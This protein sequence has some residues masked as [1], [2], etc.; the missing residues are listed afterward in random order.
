[1]DCTHKNT[2]RVIEGPGGSMY[3]CLNMDCK[4]LLRYDAEGIFVKEIPFVPFA[5]RSEVVVSQAQEVHG[6]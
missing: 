5:G 4:T 2:Y 1:M 3:R 6:V